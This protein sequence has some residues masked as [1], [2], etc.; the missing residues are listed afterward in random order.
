VDRNRIVK[1]LVAS[2]LV[3]VAFVALRRALG[4]ELDPE[5]LRGAVR[6]MGIWA[7]LAYIGIVAFRVPLGLPSQLVLVGGGLVFGTMAGTLYG[8]VGLLLSALALF[9][10]ARWAGRDAVEAR[11]PERLRPILDVASSRV[12]VIFMA[13]GTGYPLGPITVYHLIGG[14]TAMPF[15]HFAVS[16]AVGCVIRAAIFTFFGSSLVSGQ[17]ERLLQAAAV[18]LLAVLLPLAFPRPRAWLLQALGNGRRG[19]PPGGAVS[20]PE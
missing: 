4:L 18:L 14:V 15:P 2:V 7:P 20:D 9:V 17:L 13:I 19:A 3:I 6:G 10:G 8:A 16:V 5:S 11:V 12:G 1:L